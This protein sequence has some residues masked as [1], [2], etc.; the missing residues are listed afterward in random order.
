MFLDPDQID[1]VDE[2]KIPATGRRTDRICQPGQFAAGASFQTHESVN[3]STRSSQ[4]RVH[5][6]IVGWHRRC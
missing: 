1:V 2:S 6:F 3:S 4:E 5:C